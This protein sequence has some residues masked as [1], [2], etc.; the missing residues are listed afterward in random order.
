M[1]IDPQALY[2]LWYVNEDKPSYMYGNVLKLMLTDA[3]FK[4]RCTRYENADDT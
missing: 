4:L 3:D 1:S 2:R